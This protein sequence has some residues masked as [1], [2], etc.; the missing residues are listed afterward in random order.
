MRCWSRPAA[1]TSAGVSMA[2]LTAPSLT[3]DNRMG[4]ADATKRPG[5]GRATSSAAA[6]LMRR[7][8]CAQ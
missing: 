8:A 6:L 2:T 5:E 1:F 4:V 3:E 7:S